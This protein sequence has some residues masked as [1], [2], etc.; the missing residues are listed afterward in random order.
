M[1]MALRLQPAVE[2]L[3]NSSNDVVSDL[4]KVRPSLETYLKITRQWDRLVQVDQRICAGENNEKMSKIDSLHTPSE[5][6]KL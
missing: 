2:N 6:E 1:S 4:E 5:A 3:L